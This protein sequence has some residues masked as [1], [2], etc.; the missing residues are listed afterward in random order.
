MTHL[1]PLSRAKPRELDRKMWADIDRLMYTVQAKGRGEYLFEEPIF[2]GTAFSSPPTLSYSSITEGAGPDVIPFNTTPPRNIRKDLDIYHLGNH[3]HGTNNT[4]LDPGFEVQGQFIPLMGDEARY[5]P[6]TSDSP[7]TWEYFDY[8]LEGYGEDDYIGPPGEY[9]W[10]QNWPNVIL[11]VW[12]REGYESQNYDGYR[13]PEYVNS[14]IQTS[15]SRGR[16]SVTD[17]MSHEYGVGARGKYSAEYTFVDAGSSNWM[18]PLGWMANWVDNLSADN[19]ATAHWGFFS[20]EMWGGQNM[21]TG[22]PPMMSGWK[23]TAAVWSDDDCE[24]DVWNYNWW[25]SEGLEGTPPWW[26]YAPMPYSY[27]DPRPLVDSDV[28][29][30]YWNTYYD[31]PRFREQSD[32]WVTCH[33]GNDARVTVP[34]KGGQWNDVSFY[35][36]QAQNQWHTPSWPPGHDLHIGGPGWMFETF[37]FRISD[38]KPGQTVRLDNVYVWPDL[39][40]IYVPMVTV[41]VAEWVQDE[42]GAYIGAK[43]WVKVGEPSESGR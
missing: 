3:S 23:G 38:G 30:D 2:F 29:Y 5:I 6:V 9:E 26:D 10:W 42:Q 33:L 21:L 16:W 4:I 34:V 15:E 31:P 43:L 18:I 24:L 7:K 20:L 32:T 13:E 27:D 37:R 25:D 17:V 8:S 19:P 14:W 11:G 36:P 12:A 41:G 1:D 35:L 39:K 22:V 40:N 28:W